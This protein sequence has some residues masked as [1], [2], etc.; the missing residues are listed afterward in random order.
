MFL[1]AIELQPDHASAINNLGVL[2]MKMGQT[3]DAIAAFEYG[4]R[5]LPLRDELY[6]NL[7]RAYL[8]AG[9][10]EKARETMQRLLAKA[11]D[12]Q[13]ARNA[14]RALEPR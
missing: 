6:M 8:Q 1:R 7:G 11:P 3:N 14:L 12:N 9:A 10:P 4:V 5:T 13:A 2:Y